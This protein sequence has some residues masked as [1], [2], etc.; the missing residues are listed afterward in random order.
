MK[1]LDDFESNLLQL[2]S[3][4]LA[5]EGIT[6]D[7]VDRD[8]K[9]QAAFVQDTSRY[10]AALCTRRAGKS[11]GL[12]FRFFR[13]AMKYPGSLSPYIALTRASAKNIMWPIFREVNERFKVGAE[14][15]ESR[16]EIKLPNESI[17][18]LFGA[19]MSNF[20]DRL[21]GPK[22]PFAAIDEAQSFREHIRTLLD[23]ILTP[24]VSDYPDGS[25][26]LTGTPGPVTKGL[27]Y[28]ITA[29]NSGEFSLHEWSVLDNPYLPN[30]K[31]FIEDLKRRKKWTDTSPTYLREWCGKWVTDP[32]A[33]VYKFDWDRNVTQ[34]MPVDNLAWHYVLGVD[35]GYD[36]D[37]SAFVLCKY[38]L[39]HPKLYIIEAEKKLEMTISDVA[40]RVRAFMKKYPNL[41]VVMDLGGQGKQIG[42]EI[43]KR[44]GIPVVAAEKTDK[45]GFIELMNSDFIDGNV[46]VMQSIAH[47]ISDEWQ[48]LLWDAESDRRQEDKRFPNHLADAALYAWRWCYQYAWQPVQ[49][50]HAPQSKEAVDAF[51]ERE[52]ERLRQEAE[53][54]TLWNDLSGGF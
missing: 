22:Y 17:I 11:N 38:S 51:W 3:D 53:E 15:I 5:K 42:A 47:L 20:I 30:H 4:S 36:P 12:A 45:A 21:R 40:E 54:N 9:K 27:F 19:D 48:S 50:K 13:A 1:V 2:A 39:S 16:L 6:R 24:A 49:P 29:Q 52:E 43:S 35:L 31:A 25:V 26:A 7:L 41:R 23:D 44:H 14:L 32:D 28:E 46:Q 37:P 18:A 34:T 8:F 10:I 33:L